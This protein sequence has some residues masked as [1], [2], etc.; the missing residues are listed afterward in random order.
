PTPDAAGPAPTPDVAAGDAPPAARPSVDDLHARLEARHR[1]T[2]HGEVNELV[3]GVAAL[4]DD[5]ARELLRRG[6]FPDDGPHP[7]HR[8][9][10]AIHE[11]QASKVR[12]GLVYRPGDPR[13]AEFAAMA[14]EPLAPV[15]S[16]L[17]P[18]P[19]A[20]KP[21]RKPAKQSEP[22][23]AGKPAE[24]PAT[25]AGRSVADVYNRAASATDAEVEAARASL[26]GMDAAELARVAAATG[27]F[28]P[29]TAAAVEA[30]ILDRRGA[31][32]RRKLI[33]RPPAGAAPAP[34]PDAAPEAKPAGAPADAVR[35]AIGRAVASGEFAGGDYGGRSHRVPVSRL[36]A[37]LSAAGVTDRAAQDEAILDATFRDE[38][39]AG[40]HRLAAVGADQLDGPEAS[41]AVGGVGNSRIGNVVVPG[42]HA[43]HWAAPAQ[44][45]ATG[46]HT[47][48]T[49][50]P[51][52]YLANSRRRVET[53]G[54]PWEP[55]AADVAPAAP[56]GGTP[57]AKPKKPR[58]ARPKPAGKPAPPQLADP[59]D[60]AMGPAPAPQSSPAPSAAAPA[61]SRSGAVDPS[62]HRAPHEDAG[63]SG[64]VEQA[65]ARLNK[66]SGQVGDLRKLLPPGVT[67]GQFAAALEKLAEDRRI[68][69]NEDRD[70]R[71]PDVTR[72]GRV[73]V[74]GNVVTGA[75]AL[76]PRNPVTPA[77]LRAALAAARR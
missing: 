29:A 7:R 30:R 38:G 12:Q 75:Y 62:L 40:K 72:D 63:G 59:E 15:E 74:G 32:V 39:A 48:Q 57:P 73:V 43:A 34:T 56:A 31:A 52:Q 26:A 61:M 37:A 10:E 11:R 1:G 13:N 14:D 41:A 8:L 45:A 36:R 24:P 66:L 35:A 22:K 55:P 16:V 27:H 70:H 3:R 50:P 6:G 71:H 54:T 44:G 18:K 19:A 49:I 5:E 60:F 58:Q 9:A 2:T 46:G 76:D 68:I 53:D 23:P 28:G 4:T 21:A 51:E 65:A 47:P 64:S 42:E 77:E 20:A 17:G 69:V 33:D 25:A 67:E